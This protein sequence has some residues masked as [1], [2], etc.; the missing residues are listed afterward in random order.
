MYPNRNKMHTHLD[1]FSNRRCL[2]S[3]QIDTLGNPSPTSMPRNF[4][5]YKTHT[6]WGLSNSSSSGRTN[7]YHK[8][9]NFHILQGIYCIYCHLSR[10]VTHIERIIQGMST[11]RSAKGNYNTHS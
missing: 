9:N 4:L 8:W 7:K 11:I 6:D 5:L 3:I 2:Q 1:I 10:T